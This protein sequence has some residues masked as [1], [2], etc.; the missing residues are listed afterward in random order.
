MFADAVYAFNKSRQERLRMPEQRADEKQVIAIIM[1][2]EQRIKALRDAYEIVTRK[3]Y[4]ELRDAICSR[5]TL[6]NARRGKEPS[7]LKLN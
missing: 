7:Q 5:L 6:F 4:I 2:T 1:H 3:T